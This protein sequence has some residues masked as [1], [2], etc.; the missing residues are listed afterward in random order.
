MRTCLSP[1]SKV[2]KLTGESIAFPCGKCYPCLRRR[3]SGWS[4]R[5]VKEGLRCSSSFFMTF[6]YNTDHVPITKNGFMSLCKKDYQL[7]TK[8]LRKDHS[9]RY[10]K[11]NPLKYF[12]VGEYGG[13]TNRPHYHAIIFN[14]DIDLLEKHWTA[15]EIHCGEVAEASIGYVLKY[16][17]KPSKIP[18]HRNDDRIPE[19]QLMSKGIG[20]NYLTESMRTWHHA[21]LLE[22]M[23]CV[24]ADGKKIAMPRYYKNK[25][26]DQIEKRKIGQ[27]LSAEFAKEN[28]TGTE[29]KVL[30]DFYSQKMQ[31]VRLVE[32]L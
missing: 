22:R 13:K 3:V 16:M 8:R 24:I 4:F 7:F 31:K 1:F 9:K 25:L 2:D 30:W 32:K 23:Y 18:L 14:A 27:K 6:T 26:Y 12:A 17:I 10:G 11:S 15:G 5:L 29:E 19:F 21:D 28:I 20:E